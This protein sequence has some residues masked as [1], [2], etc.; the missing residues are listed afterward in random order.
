MS[1]P[2]IARS[3][4]QRAAW[5][6]L[7]NDASL[8]AKMRASFARLRERCTLLGNASWGASMQPEH[9]IAYATWGETLFDAEDAVLDGVK[10]SDQ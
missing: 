9:L 7:P 3:T 4:P 8:S 5:G 6:T 2:T 1:T 10:R